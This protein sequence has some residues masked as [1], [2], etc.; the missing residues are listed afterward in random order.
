MRPLI[1]MMR[2]TV[3]AR[4]VS[5]YRSVR[6]GAV[7]RHLL[8]PARLVLHHQIHP[9]RPVLHHQIHPVHPVLPVHPAHL[10]PAARVRKQVIH[11]ATAPH[12]LFA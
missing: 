5:R 2:A 6:A 9:A 11:V 7:H 12:A 10:L 3:K 8:V 4:E 1:F